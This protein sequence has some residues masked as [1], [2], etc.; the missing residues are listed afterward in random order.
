MDILVYPTLDGT[1]KESTTQAIL[2]CL[3]SQLVL[4]KISKLT[5]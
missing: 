1:F 2:I 4:D 3:F 5:D